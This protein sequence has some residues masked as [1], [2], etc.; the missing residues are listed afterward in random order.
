MKDRPTAVIAAVLMLVGV[1]DKTYVLLR[2]PATLMS[3]V[4]PLADAECNSK[5]FDTL[6]LTP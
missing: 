1:D 6:T 4:M 3:A 2:R 5:S